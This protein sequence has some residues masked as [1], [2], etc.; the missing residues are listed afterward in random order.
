MFHWFI[1]VGN[2]MRENLLTIFS[3]EHFLDFIVSVNRSRRS[4]I[5]TH[6]SGRLAQLYWS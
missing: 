4:Y 5:R 3:R 2:E 6:V 1:Y